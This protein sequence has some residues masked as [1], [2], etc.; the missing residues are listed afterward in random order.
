VEGGRRS[1]LRCSRQRSE[2][3]AIAR[4]PER[5]RRRLPVLHHLLLAA[6]AY[7]PL[8][9]TQPG[10]VGAD[11]KSYLYLD[12]GRLMERALSVWDP[13]VGMGTVTHQVVGYLWPMGPYYWLME[14]V[15]LPDWVAQR[16]WLA[17]ILFAAGAGV[18]FLART[19]ELR[20]PGPIAGA[21]V[22]MLS[23]YLVGY[24]ARISAI[25]LPWA[26]LPWMIALMVRA[27]RRGGWRH[28]ALFALVV[29][30]VGSINATSLL[31]AAVGVAAVIPFTVWASREVD[32]R[33]AVG[34]VLRTGLL[35]AV[36]QVWWLVSLL[37]D[38]AYGA[39]VLQATETIEAVAVPSLA[40]EVVRSLG[41]WFF[42]GN[43]KL[44]PWVEASVPY[45]QDVR[46]IAL[47]FVLPILAFVAAVWVGWRYRAYFIALILIGVTIAVG[48]YPYESPSPF[49]AALKAFA[50]ASSLGLALRNAPR[51][52]PLYALG[53]AA[54]LAAGISAWSARNRRAATVAAALVAVVAVLNLPPLWQ[55]TLVDRN[56]RRPEE[57]PQ[58]WTETARHLDS[59]TDGTRVLELPGADF[60]SYRWGN[61]VD[62]ITPGLID[63]PWVARESLPLGSPGSVDLLSAL[64]RRLHEGV[65]EPSS[66]APVSRLMGVGDVVLRSDLQFERYRT[67]RPR[68]TWDL[69]QPAPAG[70]GAPAAF[71]PPDPNRPIRRF[72]MLDE[73]ELATPPQAPHPPPVAVFPVVDP[74]P[75]VRAKPA[76]GPVVVA[77]D[78]EGIVEAA[79]AG[80]LT[81]REL[82]RY[83]G[84]LTAD[85]RA[86]DEALRDGASLVLTDTNRRRARRWTT[87]RENYGYTEAAGERPLED[88]VSDA[89]LPLF[90]ATGDDSRTVAE[91][92]GIGGIRA[93]DYGNQVTYTP[94]DRPALAIDGDTATAWRVGAF[95]DPVA[96]RLVLDLGSQRT[97]D[98]LNIT[99]PLT[100]PRNRFMTRA[101]VLFDGGR[102][103]PLRFD[104]SSRVEGGQTFSFPRRSARR[105]ELRVDATNFGEQARYEGQSSVGVAELSIPGVRSE[106]VV[107]LPVDLL[108]QAGSRSST[109]PLS[110]VLARARANPA[111]AFRTDEESRMV[112]AVTLPT[113][114]SFTL[115]GTARLSALAP[116]DV[117]DDAIGRPPGWTV[118]RSSGRL[119]GHIAARASAALDGDPTT[120]WTPGF[121]EQ[122]G[123]WLELT[124][125]APRLVDRLDLVLVA[126]GRHS[127]PTRLRIDSDS[128]TR[129]VDVPAIADRPVPGATAPASVRVPGLTTRWLRVT[130]EAVREV[131]TRDYYSEQ[132]VATPVGIAELGIP[133][134]RNPPLPAGVSNRCRTDL[135][136]VDHR[137]VAV[138][139]VGDRRSAEAR[140]GLRV[141]LCEPGVDLGAGEHVVRTVPGRV[142]GVDVDRLVLRSPGATAASPQAGPG[143]KVVSDRRWRLTV[144]VGPFG[145]E[146]WLVLGQSENEGW[147][148]VVDG[149][150][151]GPPRL[152][153]GYASGWR[154]PPSDSARRLE[155]TWRPQRVAQGGLALS[156][157]GAI[158]CLLLVA[159]SFARRRL[160]PI[161]APWSIPTL[162]SPLAWPTARTGWLSAASV[163]TVV[164]GVFTL[165]AGIVVGVAAAV[166]A[167]ASALLRRGRALTSVVAVAGVAV[168]GAYT[169]VGQARNDYPTG[170]GWARSFADVH[171]VAW[172]AV[173]ALVADVAVGWVRGRRHRAR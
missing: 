51:A 129:L 4:L 60:A 90:A 143:A 27:L 39:P 99:Q 16:I 79:A 141:E 100:G 82:V 64:D 132:L 102:P 37:L 29:T 120:A 53:T 144:E 6:V 8:L 94:D 41:N 103:V 86:L 172:L 55:G 70:L 84:S 109:H 24:A 9:R 88:D 173:A 32:W 50:D 87:V 122:A 18:L 136:T 38:G 26:G 138:R 34:A 128:G 23:P 154:L 7:I 63:R 72:P 52:V 133:G 42:Y 142:T 124:A 108:E 61:T 36:T 162:P 147:E 145:A 112:R 31:Y 10:L 125:D 49:G 101:T 160:T 73:I 62:P 28:P 83:A 107:R 117:L 104:D 77:G 45:T 40:S 65:F 67:P 59:R 71:G 116:D 123:A 47:S 33:R 131:R 139:L 15:G 168:A 74:V 161:E 137:P 46:L 166:L 30:T 148:A 22:Y 121:L 130:V 146:S 106:E 105:V 153:D 69:F 85:R 48:A 170:F 150:S 165:V 78:G 171:P 127:V 159:I 140:E 12:P 25:L 157:V 134:L 114:R 115:T 163:A 13:N 164:L 56:L 80:V 11:T 54:L 119:P 3:A 17:S 14:R 151:L 58:Y 158:A 111:E 149:K 21:F 156:A 152:V 91:H 1:G 167:L 89:R 5:I 44:G 92:R 113:R 96:D 66:L 155:L 43:D 19:L 118:A 20:G 110:I 93:T 98:R 75:I 57:L 169:A 81:G 95:G 97:I 2:A 68:P 135:V 76:A 35:V 126:D